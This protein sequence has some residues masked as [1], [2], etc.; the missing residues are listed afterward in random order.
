MKKAF[1][2]LVLFSAGTVWAQPACQL[3]LGNGKAASKLEDWRKAA[4]N[5]ISGDV[6]KTN[7]AREKEIRKNQLAMVKDIKNDT[8]PGIE[9]VEE[10]GSSYYYSSKN[11]PFGSG[12]SINHVIF[13]KTSGGEVRFTL[14]L[15]VSGHTGIQNAKAWAKTDTYK[16]WIQTT[17]NKRYVLASGNSKDLVT[18]QD[19]KIPLK[20]GESVRLTYDRSGSAGP[21]GFPEGRTIDISVE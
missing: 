5:Y 2:F 12:S 17:S 10:V 20:K 6:M 14:L 9:L 4:T 19:I 1:L 7:Q 3:A 13:D 11:S 21:G 16:I 15:P 18:Y 8:T